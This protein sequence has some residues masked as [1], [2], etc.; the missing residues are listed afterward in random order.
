MHE[1]SE[2]GTNADGSRNEDYCT[3][4]WQRGAFTWPDATLPAMIE[5]L[6]G[7]AGRMRM[8]QEEARTMASNVLPRLKRWAPSEVRHGA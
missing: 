1:P 8:S 6:T 5:F 4:C 2:F 7:M 3:H